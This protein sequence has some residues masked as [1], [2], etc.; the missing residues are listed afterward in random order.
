MAVIDLSIST[1][2]AQ[3]KKAAVDGV[4]V[5]THSLPDLIAAEQHLQAKAA[6]A[7]PAFNLNFLK[8]KPGSTGS[9]E[10]ESD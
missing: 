2:A 4:N 3:P 8:L 7:N 1:S 10:G 5:E 9:Y 6:G